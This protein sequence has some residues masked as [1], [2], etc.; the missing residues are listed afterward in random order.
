MLIGVKDT[1]NILDESFRKSQGS[2]I[3]DFQNIDAVTVRKECCFRIFCR[4]TR[5]LIENISPII[6]IGLPRNQV[7]NEV[8]A[9]IEKIEK[10]IKEM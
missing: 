2:R 4:E 10:Q 9:V 5:M 7:V 3:E 6:N 1:L 8:Y